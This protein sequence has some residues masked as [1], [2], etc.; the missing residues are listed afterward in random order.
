MTPARPYKSN[1]QRG[2]EPFD[3]KLDQWLETGRQ[4]VDGV[5]GARPG[6]RLPVNASRV[7]NSSLENVG[8][9]VGDKI[10]WFLEDEE[11]WLE[12]WQY[13]QMNEPSNEKRRRLVAIS[14]RGLKALAPFLES[15]S[16]PSSTKDEW[17][18]ESSFRVDKWE[19]GSS[20][21]SDN[22]LK[23][24]EEIRESKI[25]ENKRPLP[26]SSRKRDY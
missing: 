23:F 9:W 6:Q 13:E 1:R 4:F 14:R 22:S 3:R 16:M 15:S 21:Q 26:R 17:P 20:N 12:P 7:T 5:S 25:S 19:R 8:K 24:K 10:D 2:R 11:D 18:D